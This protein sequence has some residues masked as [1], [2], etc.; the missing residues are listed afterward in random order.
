LFSACTPGMP[1]PS[2]DTLGKIIQQ[3]PKNQHNLI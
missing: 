3:K 1:V 2:L